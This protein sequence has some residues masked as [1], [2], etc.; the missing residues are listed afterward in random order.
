MI[1]VLTGHRLPG[2]P[3]QQSLTRAGLHPFG[4]MPVDD[5]DNLGGEG[6]V[7][8]CAVLRVPQPQDRMLVTAIDLADLQGAQFAHTLKRSPS[9]SL[10]DD[11]GGLWITA[12]VVKPSKS[13][14]T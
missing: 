7:A 5:H 9:S 4:E 10:Y 3:D 11:P 8:L 14:V 6:D 1:D 12:P 13:A 2:H